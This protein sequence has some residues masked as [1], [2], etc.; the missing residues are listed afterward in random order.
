MRV[1]H[2]AAAGF[3]D[4]EIA[5]PTHSNWMEPLEVRHSINEQIS[6][7]RGVWP[8]QWFQRFLDGRTFARGLSIG[9]GTGALER[10]LVRLG[11]CRAVD[12]CDVSIASVA[13]ARARA[14]EEGAGHAIRYFVSDFNRPALPSRAYDA[15]FFHQ[16]LHHVAKLEKLLRAVLR[17]VKP[18]GLLYLE[19]FIGPSRADWNEKTLER[20]HAIY[21]RF[22]EDARW[23]DYMPFPVQW[24]D[25]SEAVRSAEIVP[26][27]RIGF[28]IDAL[29]GYGGNIL[30]PI[31]PALRAGKITPEMIRILI[32]E[33]RRAT[34]GGEAPFHAVIVARPRRGM[35]RRIAAARYFVEP[36]VKWLLRT[37]RTRLL[38][39]P[40]PM[41]R[42]RKVLH[43][44]DGP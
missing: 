2:E 41:Q 38:P 27:L 28:A 32:D 29:R 43:P 31:F 4:R 34:A 39:P 24:D 33:D 19:E 14:D 16:S 44:P 9:C 7:D 42:P 11:I 8:L 40:D 23:F 12:A 1:E 30:A 35:R 6:G 17:A 26:Q 3:W 21:E 37:I 5:Q 25:P 22:P 15:I 18:D 36:K 20:Y 13:I 10:D